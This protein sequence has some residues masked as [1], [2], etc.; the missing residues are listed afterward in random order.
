M[1]QLYGIQNFSSKISFTVQDPVQIEQLENSNL[2]GEQSELW[3]PHLNAVDIGYTLKPECHI[4]TTESDDLKGDIKD[5]EEIF[6]KI[7][8]NIDTIDKKHR[9]INYKVRQRAKSDSNSFRKC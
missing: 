4:V 1:C 7:I 3:I 5:V 6:M 8:E 2:F 9:G